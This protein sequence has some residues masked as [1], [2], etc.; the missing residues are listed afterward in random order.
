VVRVGGQFT[1]NFP[2]VSISLGGVGKP[3][4]IDYF[5][6]SA[7][8]ADRNKRCCTSRELN[9]ARSQHTACQIIRVGF[10]IPKSAEHSEPSRSCSFCRHLNI[11]LPFTAA[12]MFTQQIYKDKCQHKSEQICIQAAESFLKR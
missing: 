3:N 1:A 11:F 4:S 10:T 9:S 5:V 8:M 6:F 12:N 7:A 2:L